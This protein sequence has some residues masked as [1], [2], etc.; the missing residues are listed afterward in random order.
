MRVLF[1]FLFSLCYT[2]NQRRSP[3]ANAPPNC[4]Q[5]VVDG[6]W[7]LQRALRLGV[8]AL[9][10]RP[11]DDRR[12]AAGKTARVWQQGKGGGLK[13]GQAFVLLPAKEEEGAD[14]TAGYLSPLRTALID[15][16]HGHVNVVVCESDY[17]ALKRGVEHL[18]SGVQ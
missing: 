11:L 3:V 2:L 18:G 14:T 9:R 10:N 16:N 17:R 5:Q 13:P 12:C 15:R 7:Q 4:L 8:H 1:P 6:E